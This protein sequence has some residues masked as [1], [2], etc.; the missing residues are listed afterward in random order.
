VQTWCVFRSAHINSA[1]RE[2]WR[3]GFS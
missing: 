1:A 3:C 2:E